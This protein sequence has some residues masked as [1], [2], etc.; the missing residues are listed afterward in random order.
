MRYFKC[1]LLVIFFIFGATHLTK[2]FEIE[3]LGQIIPVEQYIEVLEKFIPTNLFMYLDTD[4]RLI[5]SAGEALNTAVVTIKTNDIDMFDKQLKKALEWGKTAKD[6]AVDIHKDL[7]SFRLPMS[8]NEYDIKLS[9]ISVQEGQGFAVIFDMIDM[10]NRFKTANILLKEPQ[11]KQA[12]ANIAL[13]D[14]TKKTLQ[15]KKK[16]EELFK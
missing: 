11:I 9:F 5:L 8:K 3:A 15:A 13:I 7:K 16:A 10:R 14:E 2:A 6:N 4:G 1:L 12:I